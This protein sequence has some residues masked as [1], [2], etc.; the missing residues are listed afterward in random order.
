MVDVIGVMDGCNTLA[1]KKVLLRLTLH[2]T[3]NGTQF[4]EIQ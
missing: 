1:E 3:P 2:S 4:L